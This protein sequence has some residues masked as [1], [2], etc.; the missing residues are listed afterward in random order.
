MQYCDFGYAKPHD[1]YAP[2]KVATVVLILPPDWN[3]HFTLWRRE[4]KLDERNYRKS[5]PLPTLRTLQADI[6]NSQCLGFAGALQ[7]LAGRYFTDHLAATKA[8]C[9]D[10]DAL[11]KQR[12]PGGEYTLLQKT[13]RAK[14]MARFRGAVKAMWDTF[15]QAKVAEQEFYYSHDLFAPDISPRLYLTTVLEKLH[16]AGKL[17]NP[18]AVA[19]G[20]GVLERLSKEQRLI[21]VFDYGIKPEDKINSNAWNDVYYG[22]GA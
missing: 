13:K 12:R 3:R 18:Q 21:F 16:A 7:A 9:A 14:I 6:T 4:H 1:C 5:I 20:R 17:P 8:I 19:E 2:Y 22:H 10:L 11:D 15:Y